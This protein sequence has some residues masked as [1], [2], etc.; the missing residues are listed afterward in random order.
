MCYTLLLSIYRDFNKLQDKKIDE[1]N[2]IDTN[3]FL[4]ISELF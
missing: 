2:L 1:W 3:S 4:S